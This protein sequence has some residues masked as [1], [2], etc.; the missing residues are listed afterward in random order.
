MFYE[1]FHVCHLS[2]TDFLSVVANKSSDYDSS[3]DQETLD[4]EDCI[5][6]SKINQRFHDAVR[7]FN[8]GKLKCMYC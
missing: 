8:I 2:S 6:L 3:S 7:Y 5:Y 1:E 4:F